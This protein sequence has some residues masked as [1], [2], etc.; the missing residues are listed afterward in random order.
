MTLSIIIPSR[1]MSVCVDRCLRSIYE[2]GADESKFEVVVADTSTDNTMTRLGEWEKK[3]ANL[4]VVHR[5]EKLLAGAARNLAFKNSIGDYVYCMD[6]DDCLIDD[7]L[8]KM[9][10]Q[11]EVDDGK[12]D[13]Y[14]CPFFSASESKASN[15]EVKA[16]KLKNLDIESIGQV[17]IAPWD[18]LYRR[19]LWVDFP[20][21]FMPEDTVAHFLLIDKCVSVS[22]FDFAVYFYDDLNP[23][24]ISRTFD[25][26]RVNPNNLIELAF[27]RH[28]EAKDL[29]QEYVSGVVH[30]LACMFDLRDKLKQP[31]VR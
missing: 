24:S 8:K 13:I 12:F 1:N 30:N 26:L 16:K 4:K 15:G 21:T 18:K 3:H 17:P 23:T 20:E 27:S 22:Q 31:I 6:I 10:E 25:Y 7:A 2:C 11:L 5:D 9:T 29:R 28:I 14:Y 19:V